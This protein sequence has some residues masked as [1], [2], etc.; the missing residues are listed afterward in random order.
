MGFVLRP[1][2]KMTDKMAAAYQFACC[3]HSNLVIFN[4]I[5]SK[6]TQ[7]ENFT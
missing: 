6:L 1:I 4:L 7:N 5:S 2:T 3:G